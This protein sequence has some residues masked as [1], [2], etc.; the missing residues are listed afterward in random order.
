MLDL[1][2]RNRS[3]HLIFLA[4]TTTIFLIPNCGKQ[5]TQPETDIDLAPFISMAREAP[6]TETRNRLFLIDKTRVFWDSEG[7]DN[8]RDAGF[9]QIL[10]G[11]TADSVL[12][13]YY[14]TIGG[15]FLAYYAEEY[16]ETFNTMLANLGK[17]DLGIGS[18]HI[19]ERIPF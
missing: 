1:K 2:N 4:L 13:A 18:A 6:C 10:F 15:P 16:R 12:C 17:S 7:K 5:I 8:C 14:L 3:R 9:S 19:V 11:S